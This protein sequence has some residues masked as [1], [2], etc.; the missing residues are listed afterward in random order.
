M[1]WGSSGFGATP[2]GATS[3]SSLQLLAALAVRENTVRLT[4][5]TGVEYTGILNAGDGANV[6][7]YAV[8][9]VS[10]IGLDG[11]AIRPVSPVTVEPASIPESYGA[12]IDLTV[13]RAFTAFP[14][15]YR[16][17]VQGIN[18]IG[19]VLLDPSASSLTFNGARRTRPKPRIDHVTGSRDIA[20][21]QT[22]A[23]LLDPLPNTTDGLLLGVY[24]VDETGDI[25][26][27]EGLDSYRKRVFR[28]CMTRK[29]TFAW[30]PNYGVGVPGLLKKLSRAGARDALAAD[31]ENQILEEPETL[32]VEARFESDPRNSGLFWLRLRIRTIFSPTPLELGVPFSPTG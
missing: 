13:D 19:G 15:I 1:G 3:V 21:P 22:R 2:W 17:S 31:A 11:E 5:N 28:R 4:F 10:G 18:G 12:V 26:F 27:D 20:N 9:A 29:G 14:S 8:N 23:S 7:R 32:S 16:V 30:I 25:A 24:P 6:K